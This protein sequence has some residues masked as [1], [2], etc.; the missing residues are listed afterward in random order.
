MRLERSSA[1]ELFFLGQIGAGGDA[2]ATLERLDRELEQCGLRPADLLRLRIFVTNLDTEAEI[3]RALEELLPRQSW[4]AL[5]IVELPP[6]A[7]GPRDA[8]SLDAI[9]APEAHLAQQPIG[10]MARCRSEAHR[11]DEERGRPEAVRYGPWVFVGAVAGENSYAP[12]L[13]RRI[14]AQS[15][16]LFARMERLLH[17]ADAGLGDVIKVGGWLTFPMSGYVPLGEVRS[18]LVARHGLLPASG[19]VQVGRVA[20]EDEPLLSFEAIAFAPQGETDAKD[21]PGAARRPGAEQR[22]LSPWPSGLAKPS[23]L[24]AYYATARESG[25]YVFTCGEIPR[26]RAGTRQQ[27]DDVYEQL[28]S[29]LREHGASPSDVVHQT[30]F[31]RS[32]GDI[33]AVKSAASAFCGSRT[34]TTFIPAADM[35]FRPGVDVEIELIARPSSRAWGVGGDARRGHD[36]P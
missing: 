3:E 29:H 32:R 11:G 23:P 8:L 34:P 18:R 22:E 4:P 30:V 27:A 6:G 10:A 14:E 33:P 16:S 5:T 26:V 19:A 35:G 20:G 17:A 21:G 7:G 2:R 28:G 24:A 31:V 15:E 12:S 25:G 36:A 13:P 1:G 9:A